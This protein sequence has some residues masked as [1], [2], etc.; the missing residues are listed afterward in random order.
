MEGAPV[1]DLLTRIDA[2]LTDPAAFTMD[3]TADLL[4]ECAEALERK[5]RKAPADPEVKRPPT[6][7]DRALNVIRDCPGMNVT[8][9][10]RALNVTAWT[11]LQNVRRLEERGLV[12]TQLDPAGTGR[13]TR[14]C[15]P[16]EAA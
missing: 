5:P 1:T 14:N 13:I 10:A 8:A 7:A 3:Q 11:A 9:I 12:R 2:W 4:M 6:N 15:Y 16:V